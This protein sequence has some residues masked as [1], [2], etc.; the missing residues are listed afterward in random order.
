MPLKRSTAISPNETGGSLHD[1]LSRLGAEALF[2]SSTGIVAQ[3]LPAEI[4]D[5]E[6]ILCAQTLKEEAFIDWSATAEVW[7]DG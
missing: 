2:Q 5:S 1:R 3:T 6:S 7:I 4:R